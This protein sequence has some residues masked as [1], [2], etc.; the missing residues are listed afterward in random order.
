MHE[1]KHKHVKGMI[2]IFK[3]NYNGKIY[4][5]GWCF[6]ND[7]KL[8][9]IRDFN[10]FDIRI[11][12]LFQN[13]PK[14][15][16]R[17]LT[18]LERTDVS[19][20]YN[21]SKVKNCGWEFEMEYDQNNLNDLYL[22]MLI[23]DEWREIFKFIITIYDNKF[24]ETSKKQ[25]PSFMVVDNFYKN[26]DEV[27]K[28]ALSQEFSYHPDYHKGK[29][30]D[31]VFKFPGLKE[32][33]EELLCNKIKNWDKYG[34]NACFQYCIGG[35]QLVYHYDSQEYAAII[36]L[37]PD[38]PPQTGTSFYRSKNT[39][40]RIFDNKDYSIVFKNGFLD[41]TE[42]EVVDVIGNVYNRIV[43]FNA[44]MFHAASNYFGNTLENGRLFQ[45]F[46]FD[47]EKE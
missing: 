31:T 16:I 12:Y 3:N 35:D 10:L 19:N 26:P 6:Y 43:L 46:F 9:D 25:P 22:E 34:V 27:R 44:Q 42:F 18:Y 24:Y 17:A 33:M 8:L 38:A 30:T 2:D 28:F 5:R 45:I 15:N 23:D 37:T 14:E 40:G 41:P 1:T 7:Y 21:I 13:N 32:K 29:R 11:K 36:F 4:A 47:L 20:F 39:K